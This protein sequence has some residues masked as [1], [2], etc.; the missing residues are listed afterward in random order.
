M[1]PDHDALILIVSLE[2]VMTTEKKLKK[3]KK[4][5]KYWEGICTGLAST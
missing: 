1:D 4:S 5:E 2:F 3:L